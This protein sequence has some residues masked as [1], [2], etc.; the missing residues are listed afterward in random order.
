MHPDGGLWFLY[1]MK[2]SDEIWRKTV[3]SGDGQI[4]RRCLGGEPEAFGLLVDK[5]RSSIYAFVFA[6]VGNFHDAE[7][8]TQEV[9][10]NA[11][12]RLRTLRR[13]DCFFAWLYSIASNR[14]KN[15][16][17]ARAR[18]L[19]AAHLDDPDAV[20]MSDRHAMEAYRNKQAHEELYEALA[21]L[22]EMYRQ[23]LTLY[24]LGQMDTREIARFLGASLGTVK[25]RLQ[26]ARALLKEEMMT[27]MTTTFDEMKLQP[28]FTF[29]LV[30][31]VK[32][33]KIQPAP[34]KTALPFGA[35]VAAGLIV[36]MLSLSLPQSPLYR[37]GQLIGSALPSQTQ[38]SETGVIPVDTVNVTK[39]T[40]LSSERG[41]SD[42]GKKPMPEPAPMFGG[43]KWERKADMPVGIAGPR[44]AY[45]GNT[46]Y[47]I[48]GQHQLWM[49]NNEVSTYDP[50]AETWTPRAKMSIPRYN[51]TT[52]VV[53]GKIYA[54][55][56]WNGGALS[57]IEM[58]DPTLDRWERKANLPVA[59]LAHSASVVNDRIY[60]IGGY[61]DAQ[62]TVATVYEYNPELDKWAQKTD[63]PTARD[64]H[65]AGVVEGRI[66]IIGGSDQVF[67]NVKTVEV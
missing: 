39:I 54:I 19:D 53:N 55:G 30:E 26:R 41:E 5:Y 8:L 37:I 34:T 61:K 48:G 52:N 3:H 57:S 2:P 42:F 36:L 17:R 9:F 58:Y 33:T 28:G 35:S 50:V 27:T 60:V 31:T 20:T 56:G 44:L 1:W 15:F 49:S 32:H 10:L 18:K 62:T 63:M 40:I 65:F 6:K 64:S 14:C 38:V 59:L 46:F 16:H 13:Q 45:V 7:D 22:P 43:G 24:Y 51:H 11:Y 67:K 21:E 23:V 25:S 47:V 12:E 66:Y 4:V 29:R